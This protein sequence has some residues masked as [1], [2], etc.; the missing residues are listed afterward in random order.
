MTPTPRPTL[1]PALTLV[2][3]LATGL[4][5]LALPPLEHWLPTNTIGYV[6]LPSA[7]AAR[8]AW[9]TQ[10][11]GRLW[12]DPAMQPF[13]SH[14]T[15]Q[16]ERLFWSPLHRQTGYRVESLVNLAEGSVTVAWVEEPDPVTRLPSVRHVMVLDTGSQSNALASWH[17]NRLQEVPASTVSLAGVDFT[18]I[19]LPAEGLDA[20]VRNLLPPLEETDEPPAP[21][22]SPVALFVGRTEATLLAGTSTNA[23]AT[24]LHRLNAITPPDATARVAEPPP[25]SV[26]ARARIDLPA[27]LR[28]LP[29]PPAG[30]PSLAGPDGKPS[31]A[32]TAAALG[33]AAVQTATLDLRADPAGWAIDARLAIPQTARRGIFGLLPLLDTD[34]SPPPFIPAG[35]REFT[36]VR[37]SGPDAWKGLERFLVDLDPAFLGVLQLFAG[38]AGKTEDADFDFQKGVVEVVGDDWQKASVPSSAPGGFGHL[39]LIGSPRPAELLRGFVLVAS[40]TYLATFFPPESPAPTRHRSTLLD[41]PVTT[42]GF[43]P[44]PW[45]DGATGVVHIAQAQGYLALATQTDVLAAFLATNPP[46]P[47]AASPAFQDAARRAGGTRG[48]YFAFADERHTAAEWFAA[49]N[50]SQHAL[51][52]NYPWLAASPTA[53]RVVAALENWVDPKLLPPFDKVARH[54]GWRLTTGR[55]TPDGFAFSTFR[56]NPNPASP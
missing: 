47:L 53:I 3:T 18:A 23:L 44:M 45:Y 1:T 21:P 20:M 24:V 48:G 5:T 37:F 30:F 7:R 41:Q 52:E 14:L 50:R 27:L 54:F 40:P 26:L 2:L 17:T 46:P 35:T 15:T 8:D 19:P 12:A 39:F 56:P 49:F 29:T 34:T 32:R 43:P 22:R 11:P 6:T 55:S 42:L 4:G 25:P 51:S 10:A 38:Y 31:T 13:L 28:T 33:I 16:A 36:R 9:Q